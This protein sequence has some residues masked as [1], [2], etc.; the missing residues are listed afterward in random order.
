MRRGTRA[1]PI[2]VTE[3]ENEE[4]PLDSLP[5]ERTAGADAA[6]PAPRARRGGRSK[7]PIKKEDVE[8]TVPP[9][10]NEDAEP[11]APTRPTRARRTPVP[12]VPTPSGTAG[13]G[14]RTRSATASS[15]ASEPAIPEDKEN[16]PEASTEDDAEEAKGAGSKTRGAS[17]GTRAAGKASGKSTPEVNEEPGVP[18]APATKTRA[19][20]TRAARA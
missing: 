3:D 7:L 18:A 9:M 14:G 13:R 11:S 15:V 19:G 10:S 1:K 17:K 2:E 16:T 12:K 6:A 20:R 4:D 5:R 8:E